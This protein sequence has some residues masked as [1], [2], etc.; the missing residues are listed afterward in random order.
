MTQGRSGG[1]QAQAAA[2][3]ATRAVY[4]LVVMATSD[5][6]KP[7]ELEKVLAAI[8]ELKAMRAEYEAGGQRLVG[9]A[10]RDQEL[11]WVTQ[12]KRRKVDNDG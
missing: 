3:N 1:P 10:P 12:A 11:E 8:D 7:G 9:R 5:T 6:E 4:L 2:V